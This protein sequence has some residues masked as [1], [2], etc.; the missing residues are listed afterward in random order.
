MGFG[1]PVY[2]CRLPFNVADYL[3]TLPRFDGTPA[4]CFLVHGSHAFD[5]VNALGYRLAQR[6]TSYV[7]DF[8]C[9]GDAYFLGHLRE[10]YPFSPDHP[11]SQELERHGIRRRSR[12]AHGRQGVPGREAGAQAAARESTR[13]GA[14]QPMA[15][16]A[17][18]QPIVQRGPRSVYRLRPVHGHL[19]V[20][21]TQHWRG[22]A[23][24]A[25]MGS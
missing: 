18:L 3:K 22:S 25:G 13:S 17:R 11:S 8:H 4:F 21:D 20:S 23:R 7:G 15:G 5:T 1:S 10:G 6:D 2:D 14:H 24:A 9:S 12:P 19:S 16:G